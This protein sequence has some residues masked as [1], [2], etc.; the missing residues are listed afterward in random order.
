MGDA[1]HLQ[2]FKWSSPMKYYENGY[3]TGEVFLLLSEEE[4]CGAA[5]AETVKNGRIAYEDDAYTVLVYDSAEALMRYAA[6]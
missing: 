5:D 1:A 4:L 2:Y 6:D 3:A